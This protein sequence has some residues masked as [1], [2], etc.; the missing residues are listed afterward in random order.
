MNNPDSLEDCVR[1][2][3]ER[4]LADLGDADPTNMW[5]MVMQC[6]EKPVLDVAMARAGGNQSRAAVILGITRSTLR[7]KLAQHG[8]QPQ[9]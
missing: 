8:L 7:K 9:R 6:V 2:S 4:Y 3:L 5:D 1:A